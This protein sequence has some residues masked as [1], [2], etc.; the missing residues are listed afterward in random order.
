[1]GSGRA[2][3][4]WAARRMVERH[5]CE[6]LSRQGKA[7]RFATDPEYRASLVT[8]KAMGEG[9]GEMKPQ[10]HTPFRLSSKSG[11]KTLADTGCRNLNEQ[12]AK[13]FARA[14][15]AEGSNVNCRRPRPSPR[16]RL[17]V[18]AVTTH[19]EKWADTPND[20][21]PRDALKP[22]AAGGRMVKSKAP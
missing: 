1:M 15:L 20:V 9:E 12:E 6:I 14:K 17:H 7:H 16:I 19:A 13:A 8:V 3:H 21:A 2:S 5:I 10:A 4:G 22:F 18:S 11:R